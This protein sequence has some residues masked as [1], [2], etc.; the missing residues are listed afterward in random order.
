MTCWCGYLSESGADCLHNYG[1]AHAT[2]ISK[3]DYFR[4]P[5]L[6]QTGFIFLVP[7]LSGCHGKE[8]VKWV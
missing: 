4:L 5:Q 1:Q 2:A 8:V 7:A 6:S 3:P